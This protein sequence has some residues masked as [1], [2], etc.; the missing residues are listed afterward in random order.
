[1]NAKSIK[2]SKAAAQDTL[3]AEY[4]REAL[5]KGVRGKY[6]QLNFGNELVHKT[7]D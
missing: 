6:F 3:R 1:M 2:K 4:R 7:T 5:G